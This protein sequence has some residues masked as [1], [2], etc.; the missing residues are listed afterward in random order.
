MLDGNKGVIFDAFISVRLFSS[1]QVP[2][3][4]MDIRDE[5]V[6]NGGTGLRAVAGERAVA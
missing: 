2:D 1:V 4:Y 6:C 3:G 5:W